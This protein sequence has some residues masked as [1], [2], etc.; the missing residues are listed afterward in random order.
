MDK[1][2]CIEISI[3]DNNGKRNCEKK[4]KCDPGIGRKTESFVNWRYTPDSPKIMAFLPRNRLFQ[5][6]LVSPGNNADTFLKVNLSFFE[7]QQ[8][9]FAPGLT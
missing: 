4:W 5:L 7:D 8:F 2:K 3:N 1:N 9:N 6:V